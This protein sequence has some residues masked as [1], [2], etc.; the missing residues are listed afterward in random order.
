LRNAD[1]SR[2]NL[3]FAKFTKAQLAGCNLFRS[4]LGDLS[5]AEC[6]RTTIGPDGH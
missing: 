3:A 5:D 6:D 2:T 4:R 1:L